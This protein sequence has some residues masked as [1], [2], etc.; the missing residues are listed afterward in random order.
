[1][2]ALD[3]ALFGADD[4]GAFVVSASKD[5]AKKGKRLFVAAGED[6]SV[7]DVEYDAD[8]ATWREVRTNWALIGGVIGGVAGLL[9][10]ALIVYVYFASKQPQGY[11]PLV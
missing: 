5:D 3:G 7:V 4:R 10:I 11:A 9:I 1:M 6:P 2:Y 8:K